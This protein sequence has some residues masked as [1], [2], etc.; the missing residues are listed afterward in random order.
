MD[1]SSGAAV[2]APGGEKP[3]GEL[4]GDAAL[5]GV[6]AEGAPVGVDNGEDV[7]GAEAPGAEGGAET[8]QVCGGNFGGDGAEAA[9]VIGLCGAGNVQKKFF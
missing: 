1:A 2:D 7:G 6:A 5:P 9:H 3:A 4:E 8:A